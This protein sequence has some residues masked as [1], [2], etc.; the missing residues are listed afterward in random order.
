MSQSNSVKVFVRKNG[1]ANKHS[2][3][4][5][6]GHHFDKDAEL[7]LFALSPIVPTRNKKFPNRFEFDAK[8][9]LRADDVQAHVV[10]A[11][12]GEDRS[13]GYP[14]PEYQS[15][16]V[17][18]WDNNKE[19]SS[20]AEA[21]SALIRILEENRYNSIDD[22]LEWH[23]SYDE[24]ERFDFYKMLTLLVSDKKFP[25]E[26]FIQIKKNREK[27]EMEYEVM[28]MELVCVEEDVPYGIHDN[29]CT[30]LIFAD[31]KERYMVKEKFDRHGQITDKAKEYA[32]QKAMVI[33]EC[34]Q[35]QIWEK[36]GYFRD[37]HK[38]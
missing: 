7:E 34:F 37:I 5:R 31:G 24:C 22:L 30:K 25:E 17:T 9:E 33:T 27:S 26:V 11:E 1:H 35:P 38:I 16:L 28:E 6:Y 13:N 36:Y 21:V 2:L 12:L 32:Q 18:L 23:K 19:K 14:P 4:L 15:E 3:P 8:F 29:L 20:D 10:A